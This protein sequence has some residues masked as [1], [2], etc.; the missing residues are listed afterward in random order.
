MQGINLLV[1]KELFVVS[2]SII[3]FVVWEVIRTI[4]ILFKNMIVWPFGSKMDVV[5]SK[6]DKSC[7]LPNE[8]KTSKRKVCGKNIELLE[9]VVL[10]V[11]FCCSGTNGEGKQ[12]CFTPILGWNEHC[13]TFFNAFL[14]FEK[15]SP[16]FLSYSWSWKHMHI[17]V[18]F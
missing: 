12:T 1:C 6:F 5:M 9:G 8:V 3:S 2:K 4:N 17:N 14:S 10:I 7:G 11:T 13:A 16:F 15:V 18:M